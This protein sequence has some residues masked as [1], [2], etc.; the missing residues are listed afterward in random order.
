MADFNKVLIS[1]CSGDGYVSN[2]DEL[3]NQAKFWGK[4]YMNG[5]GNTYAL[6][7]KLAK[8]Y[9]FGSHPAGEDIVIGGIGSGAIG[10]KFVLELDHQT[11]E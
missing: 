1:Y 4:Y 3:G 10:A 9:G 11:F 7:D 6:F 5:Y 8:A 2:T